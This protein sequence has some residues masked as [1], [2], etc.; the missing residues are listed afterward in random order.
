MSARPEFDTHVRA[1]REGDVDAVLR[2][3]RSAYEFPWNARIFHDCL[4]VRYPA[5]VVVEPSG[6]I[7][8]YAFLTVAA[9]EAHILNICVAQSARGRGLAHQ[10]LDAMIESAQAKNAETLMLEVRPSNRPAR[11]LYKSR[12]FEFL[13]RRPSYYPTTD[14]RED[15]LLLALTLIDE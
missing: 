3:E 9:N 12:G 11:R 2:L 7:L 5:W 14:G 15:A 1:M 10:L 13:G 4:R 8:G 6:R